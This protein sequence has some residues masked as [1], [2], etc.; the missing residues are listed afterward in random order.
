[1]CPLFTVACFFFLSLSL[2]LAISPFP[3]SRSSQAQK[4]ATQEAIDLVVRGVRLT[5]WRAGVAKVFGL[6]DLD[7]S[8]RLVRGERQPQE[9]RARTE[10]A[11]MATP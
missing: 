11:I 2:S 8:G 5:Q 6:L 10:H 9:L 4:D 1:M 7:A 3:L